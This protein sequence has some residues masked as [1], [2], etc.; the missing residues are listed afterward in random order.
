MRWSTVRSSLKPRVVRHFKPMQ[1]TQVKHPFHR[2]GWVY[3]EKSTG[4][5]WSRTRTDPRAHG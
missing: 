3:E 4:G 1:A 5:G 2:E